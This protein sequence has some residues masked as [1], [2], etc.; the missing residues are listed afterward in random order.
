MLSSESRLKASV[1]P[2]KS[3]KNP[4]LAFS[5]AAGAW[6]PSFGRKSRVDIAPWG[7]CFQPVERG[8]CREIGLRSILACGGHEAGKMEGRRHHYPQFNSRFVS[9]VGGNKSVLNGVSLA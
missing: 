1:I 5:P 2:P 3:V 4:P 8:K 9:V 6:L 7:R